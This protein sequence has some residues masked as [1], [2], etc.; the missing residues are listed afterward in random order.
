MKTST[1]FVRAAQ[2][3]IASVHDC[4]DWLA[5]ARLAD[6]HQACSSFVSLLD[7][8]EDAPPPGAD[9][10]RMLERLRPP[11]LAALAEQQKR[12]A[13]RPLPLAPTEA[14]AFVQAIDLW[15][16][17]LRA[18]RTLVR[19]S[20]KDLPELADE[21]PLLASRILECSTG[22]IAS[23][24]AGRQEVDE[25]VWH[26]VHQSYAFAEGLRVTEEEV[27]ASSRCDSR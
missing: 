11:M 18:W 15:L 16:A 8:L 7:E 27:Q 9:Y 21:R 23:H 19:A 13:G 20:R 2:P 22:L 12:F 3:L 10:V 25:S 14:A 26:W 4:E 5:R 24:F 6:P 1:E 17:M